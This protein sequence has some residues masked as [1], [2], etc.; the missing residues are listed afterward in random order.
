MVDRDEYSDTTDPLAEAFQVAQF[1]T[2]EKRL[3]AAS[4]WERLFGTKSAPIMFDRYSI[5]ARLGR[6]GAASV[7]GAYDLK[8]QRDVALKVMPADDHSVA[9]TL[10][11]ARLLAQVKHSNVVTIHDV[12]H[13]DGFVYLAMERIDGQT[14][15]TWAHGARPWRRTVAMFAK[16]ADALATIHDHDLVHADFKPENVLIDRFDSP[17]IVDFGLARRTGDG[18]KV[19]GT[20]AGTPNYLAPERRTGHAA[21]ARADQFSWALSLV[22]TITGEL[23]ASASPNRI[24]PQWLRQILRRALKRDP[25]ARFPTLHHAAKALRRGL[26]RRQR[27]WVATSSIGA[28]SLLGLLTVDTEQDRCPQADPVGDLWSPSRA[29]ALE[30]RYEDVPEAWRIAKPRIDEVAHLLASKYQQL[31]SEEAHDLAAQQTIHAELTCLGDRLEEFG[32]LLRLLEHS[33]TIALAQSPDA[34]A[35][36]KRMDC[37]DADV[38][39]SRALARLDRDQRSEF[40]KLQARHAELKA[41]AR[42]QQVDLEF[43]EQSRELADESRAFGV[44]GRQLV[45]SALNMAG[46]AAERLGRLDQATE[47]LQECYWSSFDTGAYAEA[48]LAA[49]VL[50]KIIGSDRMR[51]DEGLLWCNHAEA[52]LRR[53][54]EAT[55]LENAYVAINRASVFVRHDENSAARDQL[56]KAVQFFAQ[57]DVHDVRS[58]MPLIMLPLIYE[59]LGESEQAM[60]VAQRARRQLAKVAGPDHPL[61]MTLDINDGVSFA[62]RGEWAAA[63]D[64][65]ARAYELGQRLF[66]DHPSVVMTLAAMC[67]N[68]AQLGEIENAQDHC[69]EAQELANRLPEASEAVRSLPEGSLALVDLAAGRLSQARTRLEALRSAAEGIDVA[70]YDVELAQVAILERRWSDARTLLRRSIESFGGTTS[71]LHLAR[72]FQGFA[73]IA[74]RENDLDV[75]R[76]WLDKADDQFVRT[77]AADQERAWSSALRASL[78]DHRG[79]LLQDTDTVTALNRARRDL[80]KLSSAT[81]LARIE[82]IDALLQSLSPNNIAAGSTVPARLSDTPSDG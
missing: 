80:A 27:A 10:E 15:R 50:C 18:A 3:S 21:T 71:D 38:S 9:K 34:I 49:G 32:A 22:E 48:A 78:T 14:L 63:R 77:R 64:A 62:S 36:F 69:R 55:F 17:T 35:Q 13:R 42:M 5:R 31:C 23:P 33:S 56:E 2:L 45:L 12:G 75:A 25:S 44:A 52:S 16:I 70:R 4:A 81:A 28:L 68:E 37:S 54:G 82:W 60:E 8:L 57:D 74:L 40:D 47:L 67:A 51:S 39:V 61:F 46:Y 73:E 66:G 41:R 11:E 19:G 24:R 79:G 1:D 7:Y 59:R 76:E 29:A 53:V 6:G 30:N 72:A 65:N 20:L 26:A 58:V 43:F